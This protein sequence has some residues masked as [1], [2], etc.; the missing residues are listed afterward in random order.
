MPERRF[1]RSKGRLTTVRVL[2]GTVRLS[3]G[4]PADIIRFFDRM[5]SNL[6]DL[7]EPLDKY[8]EYLVTR[9]IP[10]QFERQG[11]PKR[12]AQLSE[13]YRRQKE[14]R[15]PGRPILVAT[16]RMKEGFRW[17]AR[18]RSM[19]I[20]NRVTAGQKVKIP[21]WFFHQF[22]TPHMPAREMLQVTDKDLAVLSGLVWDY[23]LEE[24]GD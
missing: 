18:P 12:W 10:T 17:K 24:E 19:Q 1:G 4:E 14:R 21:R 13:A 8:G 7:T 5:G 23:V 6:V 2:G 20:I 15:Y 9:H 3:F 16:G 11:F 22:G